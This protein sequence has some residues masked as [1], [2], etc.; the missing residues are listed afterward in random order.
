MDRFDDALDRF[1]QFGVAGHLLGEVPPEATHDA[2][3]VARRLRVVG[4][5]QLAAERL[6]VP[7][8]GRVMLDSAVCEGGDAGKPVCIAQPESAPAIAFHNIATT[9]AARLSVLE[10]ETR[11]AA[12]VPA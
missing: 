6:G 10:Y 7:F 5:G 12:A 9:L 8:L 11:D 2:E 4:G 3:R 1:L